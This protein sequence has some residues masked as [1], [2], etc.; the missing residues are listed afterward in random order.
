MKTILS[1]TKLQ[2]SSASAKYIGPFEPPIVNK[3]SVVSIA[4]VV[5]LGA[6]G[7]FIPTPLA[8]A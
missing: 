7:Y 1:F 2:V 3:K 5:V 8:M 4:G 6:H